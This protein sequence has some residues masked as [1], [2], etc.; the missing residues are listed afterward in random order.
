MN[1]TRPHL[2]DVLRERVLVFDGGMG[3]LIQASGLVAADFEGPDGPRPGLATL[4]GCNENLVLARPDVIEGIHA[5]YFEAGA[6]IV[7]TDTFGSSPIVLAEYD[8]ADQTEALNEAAARLARRAAERFSTPDW[9]RFV[10]GSVGPTTK[11]PSLGHIGWAEMKAAYVRQIAALI[12]GGVDLVQIETCQDLLQA[13]CAVVA[14]RE[15]MRQTGTRV[16]LAVQ[17]TFERTGTMLLGTEIGA[18]IATIEAYPEVDI[19]GINCA[20]GPEEML[21]HVRTLCETT[22]RNVSVLPNAG[23]PENVGGTAC[24]HLKPEELAQHHAR[25][26]REWGV[27]LVGGCCGTTPAHIAAVARTLSGVKPAPRVPV[28][29]A[30]VASLYQ[31]MNLRQE[32]APFLIHE[33]TNANGSKAF[34]D[35]LLSEDWDACAAMG[36]EASGE[37]AHAVDLCVAYV[38]RDEV[39]D[40]VCVL[41]KMA[42]TVTLPFMIDSTEA[43][44]IR[45]A[46]ERLAGRAIINSINLEDGGARLRAVLPIA[47]EHGAAL[48]AL[49]IDEEGMAKTAE[50][51]VAIA[52]RIHDIVVGEY[53]LPP[54][55]LLFD[56]LTFTLG[57]GDEEFRRAGSE[58]IEA[59]RRIK[60]SLPGVHTVLGVSNISF[61]LQPSA[62]HALN[63]VFLAHA[64]D[65]GL[66]AA[67]VHAAKIRPLFQID[68]E[69]RKICED[70][71]HDRRAEGYDPLHALMDRYAGSSAKKTVVREALPLE[72]ELVRRI[73]DGDK[74]ELG[75]LLDRAMTRYAPLEII[76]QFLLEGMRQVGELF[77][78]G[79]MQLPFVL[80]SAETMKAAVRHLEPHMPRS[81][82]GGKGRMVLATVRGDVHDIGKNLVDILLTNNG[83]EVTNLGIKVPISEVIHAAEAQSANAIGLSGLLVKSTV[84]MREDLEELNARGLWK[85]PVILGGAALTRR[86][87]ERDLRALYKGQVYYAGDAFDGLHLMDELCGHAIDNKLTGRYAAQRQV[88]TVIAPGVGDPLGAFDG[89]AELEAAG[90]IEVEIDSGIARLPVASLPRPTW[91]GRRLR[92]DV[93]LSDVWRLLNET[94]LL[95]A[96]W[97]F[98]RRGLEDADWQRSIEDK[99]RPAL[100]RLKARC[101]HEGIL[102]P[103][104]VLGLFPAGREGDA[105]RVFDP[106]GRSEVARF[107]F[108]RRSKAPQVCLADYVAPLLEGRPVDWIGL[109]A[110]TV[111][112]RATAVCKALYDAGEY[113]EYFY[114][115]GLSVEAAEA[116]A[117]LAHVELRAALGI[118]GE[119]DP[120]PS[121]LVRMHYRGARYSFG[122]PACPDL[123]EQAKIVTLLGTQEIGLTLGETHQWEPEQ[124]TTALV[125]HHPAA[126]YFRV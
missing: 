81:D 63:S 68:P 34:R 1:T 58:T 19:I 53:G 4:E 57:S 119:D 109:Q 94:S 22:R 105:L 116:L 62:R 76:N 5:A 96:Q 99:A 29:P 40:I 39:R 107:V 85:Y 12:R 47:V 117:E 55:S 9:P 25:F 59:I 103:K 45:A 113:A 10:S 122:Y 27:N 102:E 86:Y 115:H 33:R 13:R 32:P 125:L 61:G 91:R 110:V 70:I 101:E 8:L 79:Q 11:L 73:L 121:R 37:G 21:A 71:V 108:P 60:T 48:V 93:P 28:R 14:A 35:N 111:G 44:V 43:P 20:T 98:K 41:D 104:M 51:K 118:G 75:G 3:S 50:R 114:L 52:R 66:D 124:S 77:G 2:L 83:Y 92:A 72:E 82:G 31:A 65:A 64:V 26:V 16:P 78:A 69:V 123:A 36:R 100:A 112:P 56:A 87:V 46:L 106:E 38:G 15:A 23:I 97:Q 6:D 67:I 89:R 17:F 18:A 120:D 90:G 49:T 42:T 24:Y 80:Q 54:E 30:Q 84:I 88:E 7:E 74:K 126:R 95:R